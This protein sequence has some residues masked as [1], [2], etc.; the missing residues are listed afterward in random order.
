MSKENPLMGLFPGDYFIHR[1]DFDGQILFAYGL[2]GRVDDDGKYYCDYR[3]NQPPPELKELDNEVH[4]VVGRI[5]RR[6]YELARMRGW[7]NTEAG[8]AEVIDYSVGK[9]VKLSLEERL[10]LFF[11]R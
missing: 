5:S 2:L 1:F 11:I 6:A 3:C 4:R 10:R 9:N 7:P 8:V